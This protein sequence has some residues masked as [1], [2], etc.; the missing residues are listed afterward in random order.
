M[1]NNDLIQV[2]FNP[3]ELTENNA[4]LDALLA[5]ANKNAPGLTPE[6]RSTYGSINETNKL[7][8][9]KARAIMH[10]NPK[11]VPN[12]VGLDEFE[13]DFRARE[14]IEDMLR[15]VAQIQ[16]KL[17]DTKI[18]LD[19]DN[20]Q[21]VMAYYRAIRYYTSEHDQEAMPLYN[22]LKQFFPN[23]KNGQKEEE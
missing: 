11:Y 8:V 18:L 21:D 12:F 2:T 22:E 19:N 14:V 4:H 16:Q 15:K 7:L 20:Y 9:N 13:R 17:N 10:E 1:K 3:E 6:Q 23:H 5:S